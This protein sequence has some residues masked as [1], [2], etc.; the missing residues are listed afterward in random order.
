MG[1]D[2]ERGGTTGEVLGQPGDGL[3]VEVVGR[4]VEHDQVVVAEEQPGQRAAT[5]LATGQA[6]DLSVERDAGKQDL[7]DLA[8]ERVGGPLVLREVAED[9]LLD[10]RR[11][12]EVVTLGEVAEVEAAGARDPALVG[13]LEP[14]DDP[15]QGGLA[16]SVAADD[17]DPLTGAH[18]E[19]DSVE[20]GADA[21]GLVDA[22]EVDEVRCR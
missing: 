4:L 18:T 7:D 5:P 22:L 11:R 1:D 21:V 16:V 8:G 19:A 14:A 17:S 6:G 15:Q 9:R 13:V 10:G 3:D 2:D 12:V 20:E